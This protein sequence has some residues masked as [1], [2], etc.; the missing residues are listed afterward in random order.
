MVISHIRRLMRKVRRAPIASLFPWALD[1][2]AS[3]SSTAALGSGR[4]IVVAAPG[5]GNIGDQAML[6][7]ILRGAGTTDVLVVAEDDGAFSDLGFTDTIALPGLLSG[8]GVSRFRAHRRLAVLVRGASSV[9]VIGADL[10]DGLYNPRR[11]VARMSVLRTAVG[12]G[13]PAAVSGFSWPD[14]PAP[15][16]SVRA[17]RL[18]RD[19]EFLLRDPCSYRRFRSNG[20]ARATLSADVVFTDDR[21]SDLPAEVQ[22]WLGRVSERSGRVAVVNISGLIERRLPQ[23]A[24]YVLIVRE[25][26]RSGFAVAVVPHVY[27]SNDGDREV[28]AQLFSEIA[29]DEDLFIDRLLTPSQIRMLA[30][31]ADITITGRMHLAIM[32]MSQGTP[33]ITLATQGKV[34]GL[35]QMFELPQLVVSPDPGFGARVVSAVEFALN[36]AVVE[37]IGSRL[38]QVLELSERNLQVMHG[39]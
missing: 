35:Y 36:A 24:E 34:E 12:L 33:A 32:S 29:S 21:T 7:A 4:A 28:A 11:S 5:N 38:P 30:R 18:S 20:D 8:I 22:H 15:V 39:D 6:E 17:R 26:R 31:F 27:R 1:R 2:L 37:Q 9:L 10:M 13:V 3:S 23:I 25:L 16:A 19:V 14:D